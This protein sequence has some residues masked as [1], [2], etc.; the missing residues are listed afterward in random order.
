MMINGKSGRRLPEMYTGLPS[1]R[2]LIAGIPFAIFLSGCATPDLADQ[3]IKAAEDKRDIICEQGSF[4]LQEYAN[5]AKKSGSTQL[6]EIR[7]LSD[8][9]ASGYAIKPVRGSAM[10]ATDRLTRRLKRQARI[11]SNDSPFY[12]GAGDVEFLLTDTNPQNIEIVREIAFSIASL[13][14]KREIAS[15]LKLSVS[16]KDESRLRDGAGEIARTTSA[17]VS[18]N[19]FGVSLIGVSEGKPT[20]DKPYQLAVVFLWSPRLEILARGALLGC[21]SE[22]N[23]TLPKDEVKR[24]IDDGNIGP[25]LGTRT[26]LGRGGY[27]WMVS[28][29]TSSFERTPKSLKAGMIF[30][31]QSALKRLTADLI[32]AVGTRTTSSKNLQTNAKNLRLAK[33]VYDKLETY[34]GRIFVPGLEKIADG[35][36]K[37]K[38]GGRS[39]YFF[40]YTVNP[41]KI[42]FNELLLKKY[43]P[44][45]ADIPFDEMMRSAG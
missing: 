36:S 35:I 19:L 37:S 38:E 40:S 2:K 28:I 25:L 12:I 41:G 33:S 3:Y 14:A 39:R 10:T 34:I 20:P 8:A 30:S 18:E 15:Q 22:L 17:S 29:G 23:L 45:L 16:S 26:I 31:K 13:R 32:G 11:K 24:M 7:V 27:P 42:K 5:D 43:F 6:A 4:N 1:W 21:F 9:K 44:G